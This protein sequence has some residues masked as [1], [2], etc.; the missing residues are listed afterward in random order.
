Y[1]AGQS[2]RHTA[3]NH[4]LYIHLRRWL[5]ALRHDPA[6]QH[7]E[8]HGRASLPGGLRLST[9]PVRPDHQALYADRLSAR[10][11]RTSVFRTFCLAMTLFGV[12]ALA[13]LLLDTI[14]SAFTFAAVESRELRGESTPQ[15]V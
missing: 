4:R 10:K 1:R 12:V 7:P 15:A 5:N 11:K 6:P 14:G 2:R 9:L 3:R 8:P 13:A